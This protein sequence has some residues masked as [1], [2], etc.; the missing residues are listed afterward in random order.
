MSDVMLKLRQL[1]QEI[2]VKGKVAR[3]DLEDLRTHL[4]G[5]GKIDRRGADFLVE[6]HKRVQHVTPAFDHFFY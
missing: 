4:Y 6:L 2:L 3:R 5:D 1:E